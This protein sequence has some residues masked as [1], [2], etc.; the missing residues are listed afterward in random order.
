VETAEAVYAWDEQTDE[1]DVP[2]AITPAEPPPIAPPGAITSEVKEADLGDSILYDVVATFP[3][4]NGSRVTAY[5]AEW[6]DPGQVGTQWLPL[7]R[8]P[9]TS[10]VGGEL[11]VR[12]GYVAATQTT[13]VRVRAVA[14]LDAGES[15]SE[16]VT[17]A[18]VGP[19]FALTVNSATA[20]GDGQATF[21]VTTPGSPQFASLQVYTAPV[22]DPLSG[23][24]AVGA[25][26]PAAPG[27]TVDVIAADLDLGAADFWIAPVTTTGAEGA[28]DGPYT[29]TI[30]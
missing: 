30:T 9:A 17:G 21:N 15:V 23:A 16:W 26:L 10:E 4:S 1:E 28:A 22:G 18:V 8:V 25:L 20:D 27:V 3:A 29:L 13:Q 24:D 2:E 5:E 11:Q 6:D 19:N 12:T 7:P 14:T